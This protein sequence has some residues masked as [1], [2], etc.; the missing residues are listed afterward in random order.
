MLH[1]LFRDFLMWQCKLK[2][3]SHSH[4]LSIGQPTNLHARKLMVYRF[5]CYMAC[6][7]KEKYYIS[8][9]TFGK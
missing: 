7:Y 4:A 9:I 3:S 8:D 1:N 6:M 2:F 5:M